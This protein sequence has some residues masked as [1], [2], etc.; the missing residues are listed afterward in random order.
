MKKE[1][2][3]I[4]VAASFDAAHSIV[5][6]GG[7]CEKLH[8][9]RWRLEATFAGPL[10]EGGI[11]RDFCELEREVRERVISKLDHINLND[12][13]EKPTTELIC[14]WI[15]SRLT[16]L[17]VTGIRLWETPDYSVSY[18]GEA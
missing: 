18:K 12:L 13:F 6:P 9:H 11:V 8:G 3:L 15:W 4:T 17:G 1:E 10:G 2:F 16:P 14:R 7:P 5:I